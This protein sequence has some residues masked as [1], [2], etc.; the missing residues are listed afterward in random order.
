MVIYVDILFNSVEISIKM[1]D[2]F[3]EKLGVEL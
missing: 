2:R 3:S 1:S